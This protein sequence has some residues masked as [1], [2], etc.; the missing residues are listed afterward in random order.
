ML[1]QIVTYVAGRIKATNQLS[2]V[3]GMAELISE[4]SQDP[5]ARKVY[6]AVYHNKD[7]MKPISLSDYTAG[8]CFFLRTQSDRITEIE[9]KRGC[10]PYVR[11]SYSVALYYMKRRE[12]QNGV[13]LLEFC[14]YK[15]TFL[16]NEQDLRESLN[17]NVIKLSSS[18]LSTDSARNAAEIWQGMDIRLPVDLV[19]HKME[20]NYT[21]QYYPNC[22]TSCCS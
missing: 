4:S 1:E 17:V 10:D 6:P 20:L 5:N 21:A 9:S 22:I 19:L 16:N 12:S 13:D 7:N 2:Q 15:N 18:T 11:G 3:N 8:V 14:M